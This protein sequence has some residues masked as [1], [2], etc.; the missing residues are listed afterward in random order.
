MYSKLPTRWLCTTILSVVF[1]CSPQTAFSADSA[2]LS[3]VPDRCISLLQGQTCY[4]G[5]RFRWKLQDIDTTNANN[6]IC[7]WREG[8]S[9]AMTCW[10][11]EF[12]GVFRYSLEAAETTSFHLVSGNGQQPIIGSTKVTISWVY[13]KRKSKSSRWRLF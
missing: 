13:N 7:L 3:V 8:E 10:E 11:G 1:S 12:E 6:T 5:V 9:V 2:Q 4:L